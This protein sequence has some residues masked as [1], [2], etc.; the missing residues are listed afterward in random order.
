[1]NSIRILS[2]NDK[3]Q[4]DGVLHRDKISTQVK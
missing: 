1:M 3:K 4:I 2:E